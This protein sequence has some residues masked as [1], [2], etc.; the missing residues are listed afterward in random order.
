M[1]MVSLTLIA[2]V[3][4]FMTVFLK[5][6]FR[7]LDMWVGR[8]FMFESQWEEIETVLIGRQLGAIS[9]GITTTQSWLALTAN[10]SGR[11]YKEKA[12]GKDLQDLNRLYE[13]MSQD[14]DITKFYREQNWI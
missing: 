3:L 8:F 2:S 9:S 5:I 4:V 1:I 6:L 14:I 12:T 10:I 13:E 11:V 7:R